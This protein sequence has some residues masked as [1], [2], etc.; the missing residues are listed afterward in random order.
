MDDHEELGDDERFPTL[1]GM[2]GH[3][4]V[5]MSRLVEWRGKAG[6]PE[7]SNGMCRELDEVCQ[8]L[9]DKLHRIL[10]NDG[11]EGVSGGNIISLALQ[12]LFGYT[13]KAHQTQQTEITKKVDVDMSPE[14]AAKV[15]DQFMGTKPKLRVVK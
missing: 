15:Y 7:D 9:E 1:P 13:T 4:Q 8:K 3:L 11:F 14:E 10:L 6:T 5:P 2:A 12:S